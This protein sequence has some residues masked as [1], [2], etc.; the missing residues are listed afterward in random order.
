MK[1]KNTT[2]LSPQPQ[3]NSHGVYDQINT[4]FN[5]QDQQSKTVQEGREI[6][7]ESAVGL[8]DEQVYDLVNEVQYLV[9]TWVEEY[10]KKIFDG[11]TLS[12]LL[13]LDI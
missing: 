9:D 11:K 10:E 8:T 5:E 6:L 7:G 13:Q 12:E 4:Y 2:F 3:N 1:T